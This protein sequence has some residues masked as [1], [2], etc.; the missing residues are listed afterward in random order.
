MQSFEIFLTLKTATVTK[1]TLLTNL[2][3]KYETNI[4][5]YNIIPSLKGLF[6]SKKN[7]DFDQVNFLCNFKNNF[8]ILFF[9]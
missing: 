9:C 6:Y 8:T 1:L 5:S 3:L 7:F 4:K 2:L